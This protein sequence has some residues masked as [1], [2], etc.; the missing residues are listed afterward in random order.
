MGVARKKLNI[1][2]FNGCLL[3]SGAFGWVTQSWTV[4]LAALVVTV[5]CGVYG[6][7]IRLTS[8]R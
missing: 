1:A 4:F 3:I 8:R 6:G 2:S 7:N 5:A